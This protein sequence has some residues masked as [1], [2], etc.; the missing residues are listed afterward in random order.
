M[1]DVIPTQL[2]KVV[3]PIKVVAVDCGPGVPLSRYQQSQPEAGAESKDPRSLRCTYR[4]N[5]DLLVQAPPLIVIRAEL[6]NPWRTHSILLSMSYLVSISGNTQMPQGNTKKTPY[7]SPSSST[8]H[9]I[10]LTQVPPLG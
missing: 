6:Y 9:K 10:N 4:G 1:N 2:G 3:W 8:Y 7:S 5:S